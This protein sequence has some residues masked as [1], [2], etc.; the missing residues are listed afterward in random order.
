M[1]VTEG[2]GPLALYIDGEW[3]SASGRDGEEV[4]NPADGRP[5]AVLPHASSEDLDSALEMHRGCAP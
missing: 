3:L 2:Y 4:L 1:A 5:L